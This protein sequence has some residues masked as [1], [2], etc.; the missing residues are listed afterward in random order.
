MTDLDPASPSNT[1]PP[2][3]LHRLP[4]S[5]LPSDWS[6]LDAEALASLNTVVP[7]TTAS[8]LPAL[9]ARPDVQT[10][11]VTVAG[12]LQ[13]V[14]VCSHH[15]QHRVTR[16]ACAARPGAGGLAL[17]R[18]TLAPL[19]DALLADGAQKLSIHLLARSVRRLWPLFRLNR[20]FFLEGRLRHEWQP[21]LQRHDDVLILSALAQADQRPAPG[22]LW[23]NAR[24]QAAGRRFFSDWKTQPPRAPAPAA[25]PRPTDGADLA[26]SGPSLQPQHLEGAVDLNAGLPEA[27][28]RGSTAID[29]PGYRLRTLT[30]KDANDTL[31]HW[32]NAPQLMGSMN[33][34]RFTFSL[35]S[36]R[37]LLAGFDRNFNQFIGVFKQASDELIGFYT[38]LVNEHARHA[39]LALCIYPSEAAASRIMVDTITPLT[40]SYFERF[41]IQK[42]TGSVLVSNRRMLLSLPHNYTFLFEAVLRQECLGDPDRLD[43]VVFSTF[44][45][46]ALRPR[47]GRF[48]PASAS[49]G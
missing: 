19:A 45:D 28:A 43:V 4:A 1:Q 8:Q 7:L 47:L 46:P 38:V 21:A 12:D 24:A 41:A 20:R 40:D 26:R 27:P 17:L 23:L 22:S 37:A 6:W 11:A 16:I 48:V 30:A 25:G 49:P 44:R 10:W 13:A 14:Y 29:L 31:V 5:R 34:P 3:E 42:I 32:L 2:P 39:H 15:A 9:L 33:L 36:V 35:A 18:H